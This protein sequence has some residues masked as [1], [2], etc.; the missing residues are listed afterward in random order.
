MRLLIKPIFHAKMG[1][2]WSTC[3]CR[4]LIWVRDGVLF[5]VMPGCLLF[6]NSGTVGLKHG[7]FSLWVYLAMSECMLLSICNAQGNK[8][9]NGFSCPQ[10]SQS[11][12]KETHWRQTQLQLP[13]GIHCSRWNKGSQRLILRLAMI[14]QVQL[15]LAQC[16]CQCGK[17][18]QNWPK[19][20]F[21]SH[22]DTSWVLRRR[23]VC[24][25][26]PHDQP[27][28][29]AGPQDAELPSAWMQSQVGRQHSGP[30]AGWQGQCRMGGSGSGDAPSEGLLNPLNLGNANWQGANTQVSSKLE[31]T[32]NEHNH[33]LHSLHQHLL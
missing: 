8:Q 27:T 1:F 28:A 6:Y 19:K 2:G 3:P 25:R 24:R 21:S 4:V 9:H 18:G 26:G 33:K 15:M 31:N 16:S 5:A 23:S 30:P 22:G 11:K 29:S 17:T 20:T 10:Y 14:F 12:G 13:G 7:W 32:W